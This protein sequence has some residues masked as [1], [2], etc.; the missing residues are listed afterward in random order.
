MNN[1]LQHGHRHYR[2]PRFVRE[3]GLAALAACLLAAAPVRAADVTP[4]DRFAQGYRHLTGQGVPRDATMAAKLMLEAAQA[5]EPQA[6]YQL[7]VMHM[8]GLGVPR[9]LA[10]AYFW[11]SRAGQGQGL[12]ED[13]KQQAKGRIEALRRELTPD[14]KRRLGL[15][16]YG[17]EKRK[18]PPAAKGT[19]PF[20]IPC[21]SRVH[22]CEAWLTAGV[23][24]WP[25][26]RPWGGP[27]PSTVRL[28]RQ[29]E[30]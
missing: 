22:G 15:D 21:S 11:L 4:G 2:P 7:G 26:G 23:S 29:D 18:M 8:E 12:P 16:K 25:A 27:G 5:G 19:S 20:G 1:E 28:L 14:Q 13:V 24:V 6:Q 17:E 10:W 30:P 9:D 3:L